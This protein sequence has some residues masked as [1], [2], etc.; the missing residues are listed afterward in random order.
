MLILRARQDVARSVNSSLVILYWKV[1]R[2]IRKDVLKEMRAG[3]G[4]KM[5]A[6]V[7]RQLTGEFGSGFAEKSLRRM[8]QFAEVFSDEQIVA[9]FRME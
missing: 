3:Y 2:R 4:E 5:V 1:G 9:T 7:S 8:I 6:T